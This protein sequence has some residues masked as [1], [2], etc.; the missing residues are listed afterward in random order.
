MNALYNV[1]E[2]TENI[3]FHWHVKWIHLNRSDWMEV[4]TETYRAAMNGTLERHFSDMIA[5]IPT[6]I[7]IEQL[8]QRLENI[9]TKVD[10]LKIVYNDETSLIVELHID[11]KVI[12]YELHID[13]ANDPEEYKMYNRQDSTIVDRNFEDAAFGTEIFTRT[14]FVGDVLT[15]F[16]SKYNFYG[17]SLQTC[18]L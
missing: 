1:R 11:E 4:Q 6:R 8:K 18:Y 9:A 15:A 17:T 13:E 7:T 5:V 10:E 14:L 12:P 3:E 16:S 2:K